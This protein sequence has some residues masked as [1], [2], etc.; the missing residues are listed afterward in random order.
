MPS[1]FRRAALSALLLLILA[2]FSP[3]SGR[4]APDNS[5][6]PVTGPTDPR[7]APFDEM[8]LEYLK[9]NPRVPGASLAVARRGKLIYARGFGYADCEHKQLVQPDSLFRIASISKPFTAVAVL[10][11]AE[12]GKLKLDDSVLTL[13]NLTPPEGKADKFDPRWRKVT[14]RHLL[15]HTAGWDREKSFDPMF[16]SPTICTELGIKPPAGPDA[17][18]RYMLTQPFDFDPGARHAY[19][20][21][22]FCILG[23]VIEKASGQPYED[24]VRREVLAPLG[25]HDS[26]LG[27][28][29]RADRLP[30][31]VSYSVCGVKATAVLGPDIGKPVAMPYGAWSLESLDSHGGWVASAPDLVRFAAAFE[32]PSTCKILNAQSITTMF[33]RP[34]GDAGFKNGKPKEM[35]YGCGWMVHPDKDRLTW[36]HAGSLPGT[37]TLLVH[38]KDGL[39]WA[40]LFNSRE[41]LSKEGAPV[42]VIDPLVH[43]AA[44][45]IK[46]WP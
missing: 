39:T 11:L 16:R 15:Q 46:S 41:H 20:N 30:R 24:Y 28:T 26:R 23:R 22:G 40:V 38:R 1:F 3:L 13:L 32:K 14:L 31:E 34:Y 18:I 7:M 25:I 45:Q 19:S 21:F 27:K 12:R 17:I 43:R 42:V 10:Q 6:V 9:K 8:M 36:W 37:N 2:W 35:Y 33:A 5:D 29:L 44:D 4:D